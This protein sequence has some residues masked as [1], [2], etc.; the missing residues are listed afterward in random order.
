MIGLLS[1]VA[2]VALAAPPLEWRAGSAETPAPGALV[3]V[4]AVSVDEA[5]AAWIERHRDLGLW[6][7]ADEQ[8]R[9]ALPISG[10]AVRVWVA[11]FHPTAGTSLTAFRGPAPDPV[12]ADQPGDGA[13]TGR[14]RVRVRDAAG[15]PVEGA[16]VLPSRLHFDGGSSMSGPPLARAASWT[17]ADGAA[18]VAATRVEG[19]RNAAPSA[20]EVRV[21][22]DGFAPSSAV[23]VGLDGAEAEV[24]LAA[25]SRVVGRLV[26]PE[27]LLDGAWLDLA[28]SDRFGSDSLSRRRVRTAPDG[29][30][31]FEHV[32]AQSD[33][34][35]SV[36][37]WGND[38]ALCAAGT[39]LK[40]LE[41][42][43]V[44][45]IGD[46]KADAGRTVAGR[47]LAPDGSP[48]TKE[49]WVSLSH[50][51]A[52]MGW[53][54]WAGPEGEFR[55]D[56]VPDGGPYR[57]SVSARGLLVSEDNAAAARVTNNALRGMVSRD[58]TDLRVLLVEQADRN[59]S[60][61]PRHKP[62]RGVEGPGG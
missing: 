8:G 11:T 40:T 29:T 37:S 57:L 49:A 32:P 47:L 28:I 44:L 59:N 61:Q 18:D 58:H 15:R 39:A 12:F 21:F 41:D 5:G 25:G 35:L 27:G 10:T 56:A 53:G 26:G 60:S 31:V 1:L 50:E 48:L 22:A 7:R 36:P 20:V 62:L 45:D 3:L 33:W 4:V 42:G 2:A 19:F 55:F 30:F 23:R 9:Y 46:L 51:H 24:R 17:D 6:T 13:V 43:Q 54:A 38:R 34:W 16:L 14:V 52:W